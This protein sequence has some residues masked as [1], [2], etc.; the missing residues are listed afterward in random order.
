[1][2]VGSRTRHPR[3][4]PPV[5]AVAGAGS[6]SVPVDD[7]PVAADPRTMTALGEWTKEAVFDLC[8]CKGLINQ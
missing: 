5:S 6:D 1:M 4:V 3:S 7:S 2:V 8:E